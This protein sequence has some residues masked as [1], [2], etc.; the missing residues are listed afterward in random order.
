[1]L[2]GFRGGEPGAVLEHL[3]EAL[4]GE[5]RLVGTAGTSGC[6]GRRGPRGIEA[7]VQELGLEGRIEQTVE[8]GHPE[9]T[10]AEISATVD[11]LVCGSRGYR[12]VRQ[13]LLGGVSTRLVRVASSP[14]I[15]TLRS[16]TGVDGAP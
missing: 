13:V 1:M 5:R 4:P 7:A 11:V 15:V 16:T 10:L 2:C 6:Y 8:V 3:L 14:V 12:M 9:T